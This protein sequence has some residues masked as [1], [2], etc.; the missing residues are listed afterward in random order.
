M[1][2]S[3]RRNVFRKFGSTSGPVVATLAS[4]GFIGAASAADMD[5]PVLKAPPVM[6]DLTWH[7]ITLIGAIDVSAQYQQ[8][9]APQGAGG[10]YATAS[11]IVPQSRSAQFIFAS[12]QS[13]QSFIGFKVEEN[14]ASDLNFIARAEM[15]FNPTT[16]D[17]ANLLR[18][19]QSANGIPLNQQNFNGD[20][21][22][23]GQI[24]NG[25]AYAGF[26]SK[27]WGAVQI[28]RSNILST[29]MA[30]AYD[31]L[32]SYGFSL[33]AFVGFMAAMGSPELSRLD[34]SIKYI[35]N[36]GPFRVEAL[37]GHPDTDVKDLYQGT[38]GIVEPNFSIDLIAGH[39]NDLVI[40]SSLSGAANLG[41][42]FLGARVFDSSLYG[43]FAKYV[44]DLGRNG[45]QDPSESKF[46]LSGGY[47]RLDMSN[48]ADGGFTPGHQTIGGYEIGPI[49]STNASISTGVVNYGFTGGDRVMDMPFIAGKYQH[50]E[51]WSAAVGYYLYSSNSFGFGVN[52]I[53]GIVAP[54]YS[55]TS[56]SSSASINCS[57]LEQV[58]SFRVDYQWTKNLMLYAGMAYSQVSGGFAF[59]FQK[60][61]T[62]DPTVGLRYTF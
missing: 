54:S 25:E 38:V 48:P 52:S 18:A 37:Y 42:Q 50:D 13:F 45:L 3:I 2:S 60:T 23:A 33:F 9:G 21:G 30:A 53:P 4:L 27:R 20:G 24:F 58:V 16:G 19:T 56:C 12:N 61:E 40:A 10:A 5:W 22:R 44:F 41:S 35:N 51:H 47:S 1:V 7:G 55:N 6:P 8:N 62:F 34:D 28:G 43:F 36:W 29:D 26:D 49:L 32:L 17:I 15:G 57:G 46:T 59:G 31:P 14:L 39:G 11:M